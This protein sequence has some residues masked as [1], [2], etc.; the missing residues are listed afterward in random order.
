MITVKY[1]VTWQKDQIQKISRGIT[2]G[3]S[4]FDIVKKFESSYFKNIEAIELKWIGS[5]EYK[6]PVKYE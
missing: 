2:K 4:Y 3:D 5:E 6:E 1:K